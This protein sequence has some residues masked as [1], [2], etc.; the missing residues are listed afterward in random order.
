MNRPHDPTIVW[1]GESPATDPLLVGDKVA[2]LSRL[3]HFCQMPPGFCL[4]TAVGNRVAADRS[5]A[6]FLPLLDLVRTASQL[7]AQRCGVAEPAVAVRPSL[8][9]PEQLAASPVGPLKAA[10]NVQGIQAVMAAVQRCWGAARRASV[11]GEMAV[12]L[13]QLAPAETAAVVFSANPLT[14]NRDEVVIH[15]NWGLG[16]SIVGGAVTPDIYIVSK[17][18]PAV[19]SVQVADKERMTVAGPQGAHEVAVP[20]ILR[21]RLALVERQIAGLAQLTVRVE[22][23]LG[24]PVEIECACHGE[25]LY[26]LRCRPIVLLAG[27][28][29]LLK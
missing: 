28:Q 9:D 22:V 26:L 19:F 21:H 15:A 13:Q 10:L 4:I 6:T 16:A 14:G 2:T 11:M 29:H 25:T 7:L 5:N 27:Q 3:A 23:E 17:A 18:S 1:L 24:H 8:V 20:D 12:L